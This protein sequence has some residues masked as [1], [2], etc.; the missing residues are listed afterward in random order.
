MVK[1]HM[2]LFYKVIIECEDVDNSCFDNI[3]SQTGITAISA[4]YSFASSSHEPCITNLKDPLC[5][6]IRT[7]EISYTTSRIESR[8][9]ED[10]RN[11][12]IITL[13]H[14]GTRY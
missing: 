10:S 7:N 8:L 12:F 9:T 1:D 11:F 4:Y 14:D 6:F 5:D 13:N 3:I 2:A